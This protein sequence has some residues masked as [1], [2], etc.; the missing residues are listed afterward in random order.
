MP[1]NK[2]TNFDL[3]AVIAV[4]MIFGV[5]L[6]GIYF[7][8]LQ[9]QG[10]NPFPSPT[11]LSSSPVIYNVGDAIGTTGYSLSGMQGTGSG[12]NNVYA[13]FVSQSG[14][15]NIQYL[16]GSNDGLV[17][18][19]HAFVVDSYDVAGVSVSLVEVEPILM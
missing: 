8:S 15:N 6:V 16:L 18:N 5:V 1:S 14:G 13:F 3:Y 17:L 4:S 12:T 2:K 9:S 19:G 7:S 11:P 10:F